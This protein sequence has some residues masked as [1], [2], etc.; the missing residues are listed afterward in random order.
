MRVC[1]N[2]TMQ[3]PVFELRDRLA[4]ART[5][6]GLTQADLA[7]MVHVTRA[8]LNRYET[9]QREAPASFVEAVAKATSVP[10]EWF[11]QDDSTQ[12]PA[13]PAGDLPASLT[14]R[15]TPGGIEVAQ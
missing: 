9:G 13:A 4:K 8:T 6:A 15:W 2:G 14:V 12:P 1:Q 5:T 7:E 3:I 11:Y 10:L